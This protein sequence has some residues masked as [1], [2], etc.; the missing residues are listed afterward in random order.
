MKNS[1]S[2]INTHYA[3]IIR[4]DAELRA[5]IEDAQLSV[6]ISMQIAKLRQEKGYTQKQLAG[7]A[8]IQQSNISRLESPGYQGYTLKV[9]SKVV[10]A[11][12]AKLKIEI[13]PTITV[14]NQ[15]RYEF[16]SPNRNISSLVS[17]GAS[18]S[19][20]QDKEDYIK[21]NKER[22]HA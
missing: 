13:V 20:I 4:G 5:A 19:W 17:S 1:K 11:L 16:L 18:T 15:H 8:N 21:A 9:L 14:T 7:I 10:R 2:K 22:I 6:D 12:G 3:D